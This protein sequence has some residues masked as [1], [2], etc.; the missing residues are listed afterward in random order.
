MKLCRFNAAAKRCTE[1]DWS[2]ITTAGTITHTSC[3]NNDLIQCF[4]NK[5][6]ELD[7]CNRTKSLDPQTY[8]HTANCGFCQRCIKYTLFA[9][10]FLQAFCSAEHATNITNVLA[11]YQNARITL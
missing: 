9:E 6:Y 5:A 2:I 3:L 7:F 8:R 10:I 1:Y 11:K 4:K